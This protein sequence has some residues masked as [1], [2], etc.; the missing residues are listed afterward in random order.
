VKCDNGTLSLQ[1]GKMITMIVVVTTL[2]VLLVTMSLT[3]AYAAINLNSSKSNIY[4]STQNVQS[5]EGGSVEQVS[6]NT[7]DCQSNDITIVIDMGSSEDED[8]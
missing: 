4:R 2:V 5:N 1:E 6:T 8:D 7:C 3:Q